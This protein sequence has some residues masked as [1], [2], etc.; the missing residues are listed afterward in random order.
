MK[1][2]FFKWSQTKEVD[3]AT[4]VPPAVRGQLFDVPTHELRQLIVFHYHD[5]A[6]ITKPVGGNFYVVLIGN[7]ETGFPDLAEAEMYLWINWS[8]SQVED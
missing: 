8:Y 6:F 7:N 1:T 2:A 5:R 3:L 4:K